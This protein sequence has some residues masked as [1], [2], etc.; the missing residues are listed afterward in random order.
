MLDAPD[1]GGDLVCWFEPD[2]SMLDVVCEDG[3]GRGSSQDGP[4]C[5]GLK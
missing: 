4:S 1:D 3:G 2:A 5:G